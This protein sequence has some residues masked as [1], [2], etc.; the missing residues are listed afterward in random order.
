M[1]GMDSSTPLLDVRQLR[2]DLPTTH[3]LVPAVRDVSFTLARGDTLGLVGESGSGKS[4]TALAVMGLLPTHARTGGSV[5]LAGRELLGLDEPTLCTLR[6][7]RLAMVFQEPMTA[8]NPVQPIGRQVAEPLHWHQGLSRKAAH[9]QALDL[10]GRVGIDNAAQRFDDAPHRFSGGQR[11]RILIAM[12]LACGPDLLLADEPTTALDTQVQQQ[13]MELLQGL[14]RERGMA[15][16]L[17]SH[18]LGLVARYTQRLLVMYGGTGVE[19][20]PSAA[21]LRQPAHPYTQGLLAARPRL[22]RPPGSPLPTIAGQVPELWALPAGCAFAG[23]CPVAL[24]SCAGEPPPDVALTPSHSARCIL[25]TQE[26]A[27]A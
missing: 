27:R 10:L 13:I 9:A 11:Q 1:S 12:A 5:R 14:V 6:G 2:V 3:G 23:R 20:G 22:D 17:V 8:L 15:L 16:L 7:N 24:P 19:S 26:E 4:L 21:L 25:L 18:D